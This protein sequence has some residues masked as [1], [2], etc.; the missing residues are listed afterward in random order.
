MSEESPGLKHEQEDDQENILQVD[1]GDN[2]NQAELGQYQMR[3]KWENRYRLNVSLIIK[4]NIII[5]HF[6]SLAVPAKQFKSLTL[7]MKNDK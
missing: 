1:E 3:R 5:F 7:K 6:K 4:N 2:S